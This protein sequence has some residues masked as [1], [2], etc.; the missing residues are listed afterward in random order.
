M[1][2]LDMQAER[3]VATGNIA[4]EGMRNQ[5]GRPRLD[6]LSL[7]VRE[8]AQNAWDAKST[9]AAVVTFGIKGWRLTRDQFDVLRRIVFATRP[10]SHATK[11][12][13]AASLGQTMR[14]TSTLLSK[15]GSDSDA[16]M[17]MLAVYDRGTTGL[18]GPTRAD[19]LSSDG[20]R[21]FVDFFRNVGTPPD[22][23][24]GG[25]T[26]GY[27]KAALYL[28]SQT[29][30]ILVHTR[31]A[32]G[33]RIESRFMGSTLTNHYTHN[34]KIFTGRH[35][36]GRRN[37]AD[38]IVD[39]VVG[40]EADVV[41]AALGFPMFKRT[42]KGTTIGIV[43]PVLGAWEKDPRRAF[44]YM[45]WQILANFWP[46]MIPRPGA[47][48]PDM[49]FELEWDGH[50]V[51]VPSPDDTFP[52]SGFSQALHAVRTAELQKDPS[53][54]LWCH[55]PKRLLGRFAVVRTQIEPTGLT[56]FAE[57]GTVPDIHT[58]LSH[59]ALLRRPE[60]VVEYL[61]YPPLA[62]DHL[63]YA[64]VFLADK[65]MDRVYAGAE[66]PTHDTWSAEIIA[67]KQNRTFVRTTFRRLEER[68]T[69]FLAPQRPDVD[70][71]PGSSL[72]SFAKHMGAILLGGAPSKVET[73]AKP[74]R[75][76]GTKAKG[77]RPRVT[78]RDSGRI[79][80]DGKLRIRRFFIEV[81]HAERRS[82]TKL[83]VKLGVALLGGGLE[84]PPP[85]GASIPVVVWWE[86]PRGERLEGS[87]DLV[88]VDEG[89]WTCAVSMLSAGMVSVSVSGE[90]V[91]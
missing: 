38:D 12:A 48:R 4:S 33:D 34:E 57:D 36:W 22:K 84:G 60:L 69:E 81:V 45:G 59:V 43:S 73:A 61:S 7:L 54:E 25:G 21:D 20:S 11:A 68:I 58:R 27:G 16:G 44:E 71:Q 15:A 90:E 6:R 62:T 8:S 3:Y 64:G 47:T 39:P 74:E 51:P 89:T 18:G 50:A 55:R 30:T 24:E 77:T 10:P 29:H 65:D 88:V 53:S 87:N 91:H 82:K 5:L 41:A 28:S 42:S 32:S 56:A 13:D 49:R 79:E 83:E 1:T 76:R 9:D 75:A 2:P 72:A 67:E 46:K 52:F 66:P 63:G 26:F 23:A 40:D 14:D 70:A 85:V 86:S 78:L 35:W 37:A 80:K 17:I 19:S 31:C